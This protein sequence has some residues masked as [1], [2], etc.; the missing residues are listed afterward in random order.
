M[1][2]LIIDGDTKMGL[3]LRRFLYKE[4]FNVDYFSDPTKALSVVIEN[5]YDL[6][7][8]EINLQKINGLDF[9]LSMRKSNINIPIIFITKNN[10][11]Y[12]KIK[13]F[14]V[15]CDDYILKPFNFMELV[16]RVRAVSK[17]PANY[18][19]SVMK[20]EDLEINFDK[21]IVR[22]GDR[23]INLTNREFMLLECL[24]KNGG[25]VLKRA[26]IFDYVWDSNSN[27]LNNIV[28]VYIN[29]LR[30][31]IDEEQFVPLINNLN[32]VG[33]YIGKRRLA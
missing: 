1:K 32:G 30:K 25:K 15:G 11:L 16:L 20:I 28:E 26:E 5:S 29:R 21:H 19:D 17:R 6:V 3:N 24:I 10:D 18:E 33:Y 13:A 2:I 7:L 31:K 22:R 8:L 12:S 27:P 9:C 23:N 14:D 4:G